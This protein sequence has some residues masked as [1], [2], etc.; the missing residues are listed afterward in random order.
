M[1][2]KQIDKKTNVNSGADQEQ[3]C[4]QWIM[5]RWCPSKMF[6]TAAWSSKTNSHWSFHQV[7][8]N[9]E[10][11]VQRIIF[12][13]SLDFLCSKYDEFA[14]FANEMRESIDSWSTESK[15]LC[16]WVSMTV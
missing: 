8:Q 14:K 9:D 6:W 3:P 7:L 5:A 12:G 11:R 1:P 16:E 4:T 2:P 10:R 15:R 13:K